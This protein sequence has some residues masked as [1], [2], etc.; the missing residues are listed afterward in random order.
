MIIYNWQKVFVH[1]GG[2]ASNILNIIA[3]ITFKPIPKNNYD[4]IKKYVEIDWRGDS[5]LLNPE[6]IIYN[7][8]KFSERDLANY[9]ALASFRSLAEYKVTKRKTLPVLECPVPLESIANN[10]LLS[11]QKDQIYFLWEETTH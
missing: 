9:V 4:P 8:K 6:E 7:R 5:F 2:G 1:S 3:Y 11:I 10:E